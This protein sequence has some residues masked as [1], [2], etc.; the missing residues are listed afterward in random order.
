MLLASICAFPAPLITRYLVDEVILGRQLG[1]LVGAVI[2]LAGFLLT[3]K[4]VRML[5]AVLFCQVRTAHH[6]GYPAGSNRAGIAISQK[7]L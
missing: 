3:E 4:L 2:L 5:Q 7:I 1:L 6:P